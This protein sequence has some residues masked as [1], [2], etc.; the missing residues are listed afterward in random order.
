MTRFAADPTQD[1]R[2]SRSPNN[3]RYATVPNDDDIQDLRTS[4]QVEKHARWRQLFYTLKDAIQTHY[5]TPDG[6]DLQIWHDVDIPALRHDPPADEIIAGHQHIVR[7]YR[8]LDQIFHR[9]T[10]EF[11]Y[12]NYHT[13]YERFSSGFFSLKAQAI[14]TIHGKRHAASHQASR[15]AAW[16]ALKGLVRRHGALLRTSFDWRQ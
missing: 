15:H 11:C 7:R 12:I 14:E 5:G 8:L 4:G 10:H 3:E 16:P 1:P 2:T 9:P 6:C 13:V